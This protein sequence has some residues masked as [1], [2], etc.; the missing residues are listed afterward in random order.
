M[1]RRARFGSAC[2]QPLQETLSRSCPISLLETAVG[3]PDFGKNGREPSIKVLKEPTKYILCFDEDE[4]MLG[5]LLGGV[6]LHGL[7][8]R[9]DYVLGLVGSED[10]RA[11]DNDVGPHSGSGVNG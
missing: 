9:T 4:F 6:V 10:G 3:M 8:E 5:L 1:D 2:L 7:P 11:G